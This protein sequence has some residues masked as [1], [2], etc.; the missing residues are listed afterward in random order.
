MMPSIINGPILQQADI[1]LFLSLTSHLSLSQFLLGQSSFD[2][3]TSLNATTA[4]RMTPVA[5][6]IVCDKSLCGIFQRLRIHLSLLVFC[7]GSEYRSLSA[8][9]ISDRK[10]IEPGSPA[11]A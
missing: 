10:A 1:P 2:H 9:G 4:M 8:Q 5:A 7:S 11:T 3:R 6:R